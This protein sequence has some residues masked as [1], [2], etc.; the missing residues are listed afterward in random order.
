MTSGPRTAWI[1]GAR[2]TLAPAALIG[3][4]GEAEIY[5]LGDGRVLKWWKPA[6]HP[7]FAGLPELQAAARHRLA[8]RPARL[9][10][11]PALPAEVIAP[12]GLARASARGDVV[13]FVMPRVTGEPL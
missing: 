5:A 13:G 3:Q 9:A 10:A 4:G 12:C 2:V 6:D 11:L 7:D 8:E 1:D